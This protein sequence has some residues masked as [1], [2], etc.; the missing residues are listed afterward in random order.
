M[1]FAL[2]GSE[3]SPQDHSGKQARAELHGGH[4]HIC[5]HLHAIFGIA[6]MA[7][8]SSRG[9]AAHRRCGVMTTFCGSGGM[10]RLAADD[11]SGLPTF[12][13]ASTSATVLSPGAIMLDGGK[14]KACQLPLSPPKLRQL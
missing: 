6:G 4:S 2:A 1:H 13:A 14:R 5:I 9:R 8:C 3:T 7:A 12:A 10:S 11:V